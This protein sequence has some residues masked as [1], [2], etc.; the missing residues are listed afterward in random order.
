MPLLGIV[1]KVARVN[2]KE[3][4]ILLLKV[5]GFMSG[6]HIPQNK[7][8]FDKI[9][10]WIADRKYHFKYGILGPVY[11]TAQPSI[12]YYLFRG[13][14]ANISEFLYYIRNTDNTFLI[15]TYFSLFGIINIQPLQQNICTQK[16]EVFGHLK[17]FTEFNELYKHNPHTFFEQ[18]N[19]CIDKEG[20]LCILDYGSKGAQRMVTKYGKQFHSKLKRTTDM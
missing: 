11:H 19:F 17:S 10:G 14:T 13:V 20:K 7:K 12:W 2:P 15:P 18:T 5:S 9:K 3:S 16:D 4:F 6:H 8:G 1:L